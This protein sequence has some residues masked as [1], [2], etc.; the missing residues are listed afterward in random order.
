M[1]ESF[2]YSRYGL[3]RSAWWIELAGFP[4]RNREGIAGTLRKLKRAAE[5]DAGP[6]A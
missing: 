4:Q 1:T 2:D 5:S 6:A 3:S